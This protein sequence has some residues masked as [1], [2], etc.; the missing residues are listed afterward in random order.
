M[1]KDWISEIETNRTG[2]EPTKSQVTM[3]WS[4]AVSIFCAGGMIGGALTGLIAD[5]YDKHEHISL[6]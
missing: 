3:I 1:I 5:R 6:I 2:E 4:T